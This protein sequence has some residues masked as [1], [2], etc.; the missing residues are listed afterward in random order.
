VV[1]IHSPRP[2]LSL[3]TFEVNAR[4]IFV[5][6]GFACW[7]CVEGV[8]SYRLALLACKD[9]VGAKSEHCIGH[10]AC[11]C[12]SVNANSHS[13]CQRPLDTTHFQQHTSVRIAQDRIVLKFLSGLRLLLRSLAA[14]LQF[15][16]RTMW[17]SSAGRRCAAFSA[18]G[19]AR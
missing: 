7:V 18:S 6:P 3:F 16:P 2:I 19:G 8:A 14:R 12:D 1:R 13:Q 9:T 17:M 4:A 11:T 5:H 10:S 15:E